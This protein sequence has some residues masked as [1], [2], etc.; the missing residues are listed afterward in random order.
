[1]INVQTTVDANG[2]IKTLELIVQG[3][4]GIEKGLG[5]AKETMLK[6]INKNFD[7]GGR[8]AAWKELDDQTLKRRTQGKN[9]RHSP[10]ILDDKGD[11]RKTIKGDITGDTLIVGPTMNYG[12]YQQKGTRHHV[13][14]PFNI[15]QPEDLKRIIGDFEKIIKGQTGQ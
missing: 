6:S 7:V 4:V 11:L 3:K 10:N 13:A 5:D 14:R 8:P 2:A 9:P 1:M 15:M 12:I